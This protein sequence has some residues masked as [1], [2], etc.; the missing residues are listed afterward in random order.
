M[1]IVRAEIWKTCVL[2]LALAGAALPAYADTITLTSGSIVFQR[3]HDADINVGGDDVSIRGAMGPDTGTT[4]RPT[5]SCFDPGCG[6]AFT[7]SLADS[8]SHDAERLGGTMVLN[9][10]EYGL[11]RLSYGIL[12]GPASNPGFTDA[13]ITTPFTFAAILM[14][15]LNGTTQAFTFRGQGTATASYRSDGWLSTSYA[16]AAAAPAATPEPASLL[17]LGTGLAGVIAHRRK[18]GTKKLG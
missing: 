12:A 10:I 9:G 6:D 5:L 18:A 4:Y 16:F 2:T 7:L 17:L 1:R 13:T 15:S 3:Q 8:V 14:A 11:E